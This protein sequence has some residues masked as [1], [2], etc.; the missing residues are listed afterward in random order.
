[1]ATIDYYDSKTG[2]K[3]SL[4]LGPL[5]S[6]D[7]LP[8]LV[9]R[10]Q[11]GEQSDVY[12]WRGKVYGGS[13]GSLPADVQRVYDAYTGSGS[14]GVNLPASLPATTGDALIKQALDE[15]DKANAANEKRYKEALGGIPQSQRLASDS[16]ALIDRM[17]KA[18]TQEAGGL[19]QSAIRELE[20]SGQTAKNDITREYGNRDA[21]TKQNLIDRGLFTSTIA[22]SESRRNQEARDRSLNAVDESVRGQKS[23]LFTQYSGALAGLRGDEVAAK[24][25]LLG[26][27]LGLQGEKRNIIQNR[28]DEG[29]NFSDIANFYAAQE[30]AKAKKKGSNSGI[31]SSIL[32]NAAGGLFG[33]IGSS[34]FGG[35]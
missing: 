24:Q 23:G 32:G 9:R 31:F 28:V 15:R 2:Q 26:A 27:Q 12:R 18:R 19:Y 10:K 22:G 14:G 6:L 29:P 3:K 25:G 33:A 20:T 35:I 30:Q 8:Q 34:L 5:A 13:L 17:L 1:M 4:D 11:G 16:Y 21:Q 7:D